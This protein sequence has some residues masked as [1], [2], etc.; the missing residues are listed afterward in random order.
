MFSLPPYI[1]TSRLHKMYYVDK[2]EKLENHV[3]SNPKDYQ[4][5]VAL[6]IARSDAIHHERKRK[7]DMR[8]KKVA[9]YRRMLDE[10][11]RE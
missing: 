7:M 9:E 2:I 10:Q 5:V 6:L 4:A 8:L 11:E 3:K 1:L